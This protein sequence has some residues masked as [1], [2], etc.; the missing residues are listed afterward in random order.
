MSWWRQLQSW[1]RVSPGRDRNSSKRDQW[2]GC[3]RNAKAAAETSQLTQDKKHGFS[4]SW[5]GAE[6]NE[7]DG[8]KATANSNSH[9]STSDLTIWPFGH[10]PIR[11]WRCPCPTLVRRQPANTAEQPCRQLK[12]A[13]ASGWQS[14]NSDQDSTF[15]KVL[16]QSST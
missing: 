7:H 11:A 4:G 12:I 3:T 2:G 5:K 13:Q 10:Q 14:R 1:R 15:A 16:R 9:A 8:R 6:L